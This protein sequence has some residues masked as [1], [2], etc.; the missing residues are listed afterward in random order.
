MHSE[1]RLRTEHERTDVER[2]AGR[3]GDPLLFQLDQFAESVENDVYV[4]L[5]HA[6]SFRA[7]VHADEVVAGTEHRDLA[8]RVLVRLQPLEYALTV[9]QRAARGRDAEV[10]VGD[11]L[12]FAPAA[13]CRVVLH[14]EHVVGEV[15]SEAELREVG[16]LFPFFDHSDFHSYLLAP[17]RLIEFLSVMHECVD[18]HTRAVTLCG[19]PCR[20]WNASAPRRGSAAAPA[21]CTIS[22]TSC[23]GAAIVRHIRPIG[24]M[25]CVRTTHVSCSCRVLRPP[26]RYTHRV[27]APHR[28]SHS[29]VER[30]SEKP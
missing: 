18:A 2:S 9:M 21:F 17:E 10:V 5:R 30:L 27:F 4:E 16:L 19:S 29:P 24:R 25:P 22:H 13:L 23:S 1:E 3:G 7:S 14:D 26:T 15:L 12:G 8:L 6:Q 11:D 20:A 28:L